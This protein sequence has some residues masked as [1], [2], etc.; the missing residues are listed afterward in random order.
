MHGEI[1]DKL[2]NILN[3]AKKIKHN[4]IKNFRQMLKDQ[5]QWKRMHAFWHLLED[6][7]KTVQIRMA[8]PAKPATIYY[9]FSSKQQEARIKKEFFI[10]C[11]ISNYARLHELLMRYYIPLEELRTKRGDTL[12]MISAHMGDYKM[13]RYLLSRDMDP[14]AQNYDGDTALHFALNDLKIKVADLLI[15]NG[16]DEEMKNNKGIA[17]WEI[18][19][20]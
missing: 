10:N 7:E 14:N 13:V 9:N 16:A 8:Q 20:V 18:Y 1:R 12:L 5:R 6:K 2:A 3:R 15:N 17:P 19:N 4:Q 11:R